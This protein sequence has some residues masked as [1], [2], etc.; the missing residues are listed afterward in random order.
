MWFFEVNMK[1]LNMKILT[2]DNFA[3]KKIKHTAHEGQM[4]HVTIND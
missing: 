2:I 4:S 3:K 1:M